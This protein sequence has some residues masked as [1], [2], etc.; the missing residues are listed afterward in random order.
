MYKNINKYKILF[1][2]E[3]DEENEDIQLVGNKRYISGCIKNESK[4]IINLEEK[5]NNISLNNK[6]NNNKIIKIKKIPR[7]IGCGIYE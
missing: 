5:L 1:E 4:D 2:N 3:S 6:I 7:N